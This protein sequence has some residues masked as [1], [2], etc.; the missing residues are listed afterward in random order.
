MEFTSPSGK[1]PSITLVLN[2]VIVSSLRCGAQRCIPFT[3]YFTFDHWIPKYRQTRPQS[4]DAMHRR[5]FNFPGSSVAAGLPPSPES[6]AGSFW[7]EQVGKY[8]L[9]D[10]KPPARGVMGLPAA[11]WFEAILGANHAPAR[12]F[13][14]FRDSCARIAR[15]VGPRMNVNTVAMMKIAPPATMVLIAPNA[16]TA[17][18][19]MRYPTIPAREKTTPMKL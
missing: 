1:I 11:W 2:L 5:I 9:L 18:P 16:G 7:S 6:R 15:A 12:L 14:S 4:S 13:A 17:H 10:Q 3:P 8:Y 19:V